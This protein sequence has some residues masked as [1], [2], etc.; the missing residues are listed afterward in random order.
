[1]KQRWKKWRCILERNEDGRSCHVVENILGRKSI[2]LDWKE[3]SDGTDK[4]EELKEVL[5]AIVRK[6]LATEKVTLIPFDERKAILDVGQLK[7]DLLVAETSI[8]QITV[9]WKAGD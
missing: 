9:E 7:M 4:S 6:T 5:D 1:M 8:S 3:C 2:R